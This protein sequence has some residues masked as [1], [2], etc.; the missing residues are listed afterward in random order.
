MP[1]LLYALSPSVRDLLR[2]WVNPG[3][4]QRKLPDDVEIS[5]FG[6]SRAIFLSESEYTRRL[7]LDLMERHLHDLQVFDVKELSS[8][9]LRKR[10]I[11]N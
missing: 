10:I 6:S 7:V 8:Q 2:S 9:D 5:K 11:S 1:F 3:P 4:K